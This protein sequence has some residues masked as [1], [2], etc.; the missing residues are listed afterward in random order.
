[1]S[2]W[3]LLGPEPDDSWPK[4]EH[5]V[6]LWHADGEYAVGF[7]RPPLLSKDPWWWSV[8]G[9]IAFDCRSGTVNEGKI[10]WR[11]LPVAPGG[12]PETPQEWMAE[13]LVLDHPDLDP[14]VLDLAAGLLAAQAMTNVRHGRVPEDEAVNELVKRLLEGGSDDGQ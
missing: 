5:N 9:R 4:S 10:Y 14:A 13:T 7:W 1:M 3:I 12:G 8:D 6:L 2:A 11:E